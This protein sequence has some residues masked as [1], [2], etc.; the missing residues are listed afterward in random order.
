MT[1]VTQIRENTL[2]VRHDTQEAASVVA[3]DVQEQNSSWFWGSPARV[4]V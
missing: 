1:V 4:R 2:W 3:S